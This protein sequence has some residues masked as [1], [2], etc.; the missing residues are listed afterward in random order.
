MVRTWESHKAEE[1]SRDIVLNNAEEYHS[2]RGCA[3]K[4]GKVAWSLLKFLNTSSDN[5]DYLWVICGGELM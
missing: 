2:H 5:V 3:D 4:V 1:L